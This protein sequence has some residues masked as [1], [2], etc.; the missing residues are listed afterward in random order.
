MFFERCVELPHDR[1]NRL[2][3]MA[4]P[5]IQ[6]SLDRQEYHVNWLNRK[7]KS[8]IALTAVASVDRAKALDLTS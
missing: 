3:T 6:V 7:D 4:L 8:H 2:K 1:E 5:S